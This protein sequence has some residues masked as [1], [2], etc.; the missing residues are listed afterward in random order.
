LEENWTVDNTTGTLTGNSITD[1]TINGDQPA[2]LQLSLFGNY[3]TDAI[4]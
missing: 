2:D 1:Y 3:L 4:T